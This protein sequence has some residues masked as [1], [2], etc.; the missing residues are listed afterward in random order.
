MTKV[1][2]AACLLVAIAASG[3]LAST[4][5]IN[6]KPD[7]TGT[8]EQTTTMT[9]EAVKQLKE[10]M[11]A[12]AEKMSD[13]A[14]QAKEEELFS[15]AQVQAA[16]GKMGPGVRFVSSA[17]INTADAEGIKAIYAFDDIN[18]LRIDQKPNA[19]IEGASSPAGSKKPE[20][21]TFRL[22][23]QANGN[24][25]LTIDFPTDPEKE[26]KAD[27]SPG[28]KPKGDVPPQALEMMKQMFK[29]LRVEII[30]QV[31]GQLVK[32]NSPHVE[33]NK[34]TLLAI[35]FE[36]ILENEA[37]L[38]QIQDPQSIEE[39]KALLKKIPGIKVNLEKEVTIEFR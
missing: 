30:T 38:K 32:T 28:E 4:T 10:M 26:P 20:E 19:P 39:A 24:S 23:K 22:A 34:V 1:K 9:A 35:D 33:G 7:G 11:S 8:V 36:K 2:L 18:T 25:V 29:G 5:V 21:V 14:V 13:G 12:F 15:E 6:V 37:V 27:K 3:C 16:A 17:K 31:V